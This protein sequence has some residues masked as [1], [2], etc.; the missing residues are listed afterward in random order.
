MKYRCDN[1]LKTFS[2]KQRLDYHVNK[3][4]PCEKTKD[5]TNVDNEELEKDRYIAKLENLI[6]SKGDVTYN[7]NIN[8]NIDNSNINDVNLLHLF[9]QIKKQL[10]P[11]YVKNSYL[12]PEK[13]KSNETLVNM[14]KGTKLNINV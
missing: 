11:N 1:C 12:N 9:Q 6:K 10:N 8:V 14:I 7:I 4:K 5:D 13:M 3:K 2:S